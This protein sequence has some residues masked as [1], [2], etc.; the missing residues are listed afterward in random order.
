MIAIGFSEKKTVLSG[1]GRS[2]TLS[3]VIL[4]SPGKVCVTLNHRPLRFCFS[5]CYK[6]TEPGKRLRKETTYGDERCLEGQ[7]GRP[8]NS[9]P[10]VRSSICTEWF[11][12]TENK[13]HPS[14]LCL[15]SATHS[16][17][18]NLCFISP[19]SRTRPSSLRRE[20]GCQ[21]AK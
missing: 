2:L 21:P 20:Y 6:K 14:P 19:S 1:T 8:S 5:C 10:Q 4:V 15:A 12:K 17:S 7:R 16:L 13:V 3:T 18:L 11:T 9:I